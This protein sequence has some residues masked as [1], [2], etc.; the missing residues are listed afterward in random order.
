MLH[1]FEASIKIAINTN[2][3]GNIIKRNH[4]TSLIFH[5][6]PSIRL[7]DSFKVDFLC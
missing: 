5:A 6:F 7:A 4:P 1:S 3:H 2:N